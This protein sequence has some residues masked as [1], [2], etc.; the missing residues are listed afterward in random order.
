MKF[1]AVI[2]AGG[3]I[4]AAYAEAIGSPY[5]ALAPF[6]PENRPVLQHI[7]HALRGSGQIRRIICVAPE[8]V[9]PFIDGVDLWKPA[10]V[11]GPDNI[12]LGLSEAT[13]G[14]PAVICTSD[15]PFLTAQSLREFLNAC[16]TDAQVAVGMVEANAYNAAFQNAPPS[17][18][19]RLSD[20]GPVTLGGLFLV[21]PDLL[22]RQ[23]ALF[24]QIFEGRKDQW[25]MASLLG[26]RLL[27]QF[28]TKTLCQR[29]IVRR[30]ETLLGGTVQVIPNAA[31]GLAYDI[32][33]LDDYTYAQTHFTEFHG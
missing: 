18:F 29:D 31:P 11:S 22:T 14:I 33:T 8:A 26:P 3:T 5:R 6:G 7:V 12:R 16:R 28:A 15:L 25:R 21:Q 23:E 30:A 32:D 4:D 9:V 10:G 24:R 1:D 27:W 20:V 2:P 19:V 17:E 13:L